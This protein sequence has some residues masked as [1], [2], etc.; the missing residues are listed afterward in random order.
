MDKITI[1]G[2]ELNFGQVQTIKS[3][4]VDFKFTL[5]EAE[6]VQGDE[7]NPKAT[8]FFK[9]EVSNIEGMFHGNT[10]RT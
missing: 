5:S 2:I 6:F 9:K 1:N 8:A 10:K 7:F 4:L 3:S